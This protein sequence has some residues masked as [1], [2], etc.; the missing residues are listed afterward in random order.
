MFVTTDGTCY[1]ATGWDEDGS[2]IGIYRD[3]EVIGSAGHTHGWGYGGGGAVTA[4]RSALF[5]AQTVG[6]EGGDLKGENTWPVKGKVWYGISRR[7]RDGS[8]APFEGGKGGDGDTLPGGFLK[9]NEVPEG[10]NAEITGLAVDAMDH[11]F[12][13]DPYN[14]Q[15]KV[16]DTIKMSL[17]H[18]W[19]VERAVA[20]AAGAKGELWAVQ[21]GAGD[22]AAKILHFSAE[23]K[24]IPDGF[25]LP[26]DVKPGGLCL[27]AKGRLLVTDRGV[28]Q[29]VRIYDTHNVPPLLTGTLG[30]RGG[31]FAGHGAEI[32]RDGPLRFNDPVGVGMDGMGNLYVCSCGSASGGGTVLEC[33]DEDNKRLWR[34]FGLAFLDTADADP[35][36]DG[37]DVYTKDKHY[38]MDYS[39]AGGREATYRGY[40]LNR[41]KYPEDARLRSNECGVFFRRILGK[42]FLFTIDMYSGGL[43]IFR[44]KPDTDGECAIPSG[45]FAKQHVKPEPSALKLDWPAGQPEK[46]EWIW[47]DANGNGSPER[48]E[49]DSR[50]VDAPGLWGWCVDSQGTIWQATEHD[51][52]RK[53]A[54]QGLDKLGNP[55]YT[56]AS[57][58]SLPTP[59]LFTELCRAEYVPETDTMFLSGYTTDRPHRGGEWGSV[60]TEIVRYEKWNEGNRVPSVMIVLPYDGLKDARLFIKSFAVAGDYVFA[61][62]SREPSA[63]FVFEAKTGKAVGKLQADETVG[64]SSGWLD[65]P[66]AVRAFRR[67]NGGYLVFVEEDLDAKVIVYRWKP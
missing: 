1:A 58:Q 18:A 40:T 25:E 56:Y 51:G 30:A 33:Y 65:F 60:G 55:I 46:G 16:Y 63:V 42:S 41:F 5:F 11:L 29:Q 27:D 36:H 66:Y 35:L 4:S 50:P 19:K 14:G 17:L 67:S 6:N 2:E 34:L 38:V 45:W 26:R 24:L 28:A 21:S 37:L 59:A 39:K 57:I 64:Q 52:I 10:V 22:A 8:A 62:E 15:I 61:G 49:Y 20:L 23:G 53:F 12:V 44:F 54:V 31:I 3:G 32:G 47:R 7:N 43:R 13:S 48:D 9:I